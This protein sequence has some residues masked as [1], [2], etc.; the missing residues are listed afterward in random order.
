MTVAQ[1]DNFF[2]P[3]VEQVIRLRDACR[4]ATLHRDLCAEEVAGL[5][6]EQWQNLSQ[7]VRRA[8]VVRLTGQT[9]D[10]A[11]ARLA[12]AEAAAR[13]LQGELTEAARACPQLLGERGT[14]CPKTS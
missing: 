7:P 4:R 3:A 5:Q 10:Q 11:R 12:Q 9:L 8:L 13:R 14:P 1:L 6:S 2:T